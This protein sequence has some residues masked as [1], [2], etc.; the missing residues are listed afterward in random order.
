MSNI[1][2]LFETDAQVE[3]KGVIIDYGDFKV[4]IARAGGANKK[5]ERLL[6]RKTRPHRRAIATESMSDKLAES[7]M[8]EIYA[9]TIMLDWEG[10]TDDDGNV[11]PFSKDAVLALFKELPDFY[12]DIVEQSQKVALFRKTLQED[13]SGN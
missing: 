6:S 10:V 12:R 4:R 5:F 3:T 2:R 11:I 8:M 9:E 1:G 7:I 13:D